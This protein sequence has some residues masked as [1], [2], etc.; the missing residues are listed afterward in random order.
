[1]FGVLPKGTK[2]VIVALL[3]HPGLWYTAVRLAIR[4]GVRPDNSY[5]RFRMLTMYGDTTTEP[6][7]SDLVAYVSWCK[8]YQQYLRQLDRSSR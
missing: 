6:R 7:P 4:L 5:M 3:G 1:M 8:Q 2:G